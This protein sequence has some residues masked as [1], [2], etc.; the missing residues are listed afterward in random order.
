MRLTDPVLQPEP[1]APPDPRLAIAGYTSG[2]Y[3]A[4]KAQCKTKLRIAPY[5]VA[6]YKF[7]PKISIGPGPPDS[8]VVTGF[9][10]FT[11]E[12]QIRTVFSSYGDIAEFSNKTDPTTGSFLGIAMIK[13]KDRDGRA[14][15][16]PSIS[17]VLAARAAEKDGTG[18]RIG[19]CEVKAQ[20]DRGRICKQFVD[21]A[22]RRNKEERE[23]NNVFE[24][25]QTG[26][27]TPAQTPKPNID[28][29]GPPPDAPKGPSGKGMRP[30]EGPRMAVPIKPP[31]HSLVESESILDNIKRKPYIFI[32]HC[33]VPV[34]GTTIAHLKKRLKLYDWREVRVDR[35]GYFIIF[36]ESKHGEDE[37]VRCYNECNMTALF[38]YVMNMEC[39]Q[40]GNPCY[41]R[42]PSPERVLA[43]K[44][45]REEEERIRR[46]DELDF[47]EEKKQRAL[48]MDPVKAALELVLPE[49][50]EKI[51]GDVKS[52]IAAPALY[53]YLDPDRHVAKRRKMNIPD[54]AEKESARPTLILNRGDET[55][56]VGTPDS[57][58]GFSGGFRKQG[59]RYD[60]SIARGRRSI[61]ARPVNA[62]ADERRKRPAPPRRR[63]LQPLHHRLQNF[64]DNEG[65]S[66]DEQ[67]TPLTR[68]TEEQES[69]PLS[70]MSRS[71][72]PH[73]ADEDV[74][75]T[76]R[77]P[78]RRKLEPG[79][80]AESDDEALD[81]VARRSLGHLLHKEP[82]DMAMRELEQ[83]LSCLPRS[84][85]LRKRAYIEV[86][87]R[88]KA[89][90]DDELFFGIKHVEE[91]PIKTGVPVADIVLDSI[92]PANSV[93]T[94]EPGEDSAKP[95]TK[96]KV[97]KKRKSKKQILEERE[98]LKAEAR[99]AKALIQEGAED[100]LAA[101]EIE[102]ERIFETPEEEPRAEVEWGVSTDEPR[103][104]VEDDP[105]AVLDIDG[106]QH[107]LKDDEDMR[108]LTKAMRS[109]L[110]SDFDDAN[111]WAWKQKE[112]KALNNGNQYG[113]VR[114]EQ[115][116][117][118]YYVPNA[119]GCARTEGVKKILE[120]EK[121]KYLPHRIRVQRQREAREANAKKDGNEAA[122]LAVAA[123]IA[124]T[125]SSRS[126]RANNRRLVND[127]NTQKLNLSSAEAD[128]LRFNQ[129]KKRRKL[130]KFDRSH[131]HNWGL[132]AEE[133]IAVN[134]MIIEYV[135]EKVR[136][137]VADLREVR[138]L[139]Q[140]IGSSYLFRIDE[141]TVIDATKKGGI[142]RFI[143]HSCTPNCTAKI[144]KVDGTKRI[145]IY[146][147][148]D[149]SK[150]EFS[151]PVYMK[152]VLMIRADEELTYDYKFER[153]INS[154][155][156]IP[157]LCGSVG[158]KGFLN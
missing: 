106:W 44:R 110:A 145:V 57:R 122:K 126:N 42:S 49:L 136:Q 91:K 118:G 116:I 154:D 13:Y 74:T 152:F 30:P 125:A 135:G 98:S 137:R 90:K 23:K 146:A 99:S 157:C 22:V 105:E 104:T 64:F 102:D 138:Y 50:V 35:T 3:N 151:V 84:S 56:S 140:G 131:I 16:G 60:P 33:Y 97:T 7:D 45:K 123:K 27:P 112:I 85:K 80:G 54:P 108:F 11:P 72:T 40:Y 111:F 129:L 79:W 6:P 62:F 10:P 14:G 19:V 117:E 34:L 8:V 81:V 5:K 25:T 53:D 155:D 47:E 66:D 101:H 48:C 26:T 43:E 89:E 132:Y 73:A 52:R 121:S 28:L 36:E 141:D 119:T 67:R 128:A 41:E 32:A 139:R 156:R 103:R 115:R 37:T 20:R 21:R 150:S 38:T 2:L 12:S 120:S 88:K 124:S 63:D 15:R 94:V 87:L 1:S 65:D 113:V 107:M 153:E 24:P 83:V 39:Q 134:D 100:K 130:V 148:R 144:I 96:A 76:P 95:A 46:E 78:K 9:D 71:S 61:V 75:G 92:Q 93:E 114:S 68:D 77:G 158:C 55:P 17:A 70:R 58:A 69:R 133:S 31:A 59:S 18:Q 29:S 109:E 143:N 86:E 142:A 82:E 127:I 4:K 51:M 149:I 147:L